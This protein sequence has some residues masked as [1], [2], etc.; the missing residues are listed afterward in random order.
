MAN[1]S[2]GLYVKTNLDRSYGGQRNIHANS[3]T[4]AQS[5]VM[6][7]RNRSSGPRV[8]GNA[9]Q[10][11]RAET[12]IKGGSNNLSQGNLAMNQF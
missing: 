6:N 1:Q 11:M 9:M 10:Q 7:L 4:A 12:S 2:N 8:I 5:Q 3:T